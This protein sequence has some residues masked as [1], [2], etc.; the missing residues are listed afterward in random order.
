MIPLMMFL[1]LGG[2]LALSTP[3]QHKTGERREQQLCHAAYTFALKGNG[4]TNQNGKV[5]I[6]ADQANDV[7]E[8]WRLK[9]SG[10]EFLELLVKD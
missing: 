6:T 1:I 7:L 5:R 9:D 4:V 2:S 8:G 10:S 3:L